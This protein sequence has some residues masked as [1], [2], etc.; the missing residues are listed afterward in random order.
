MIRFYKKVNDFN[1]KYAF[2]EIALI[3]VGITLA[4]WFN[5]WN[6]N[7]I[8]NSKK[9]QYLTELKSDLQND[10]D[11][12]SYLINANQRRMR[13][14]NLLNEIL[15]N[16]KLEIN[17]D[18]VQKCMASASFINVFTGSSTVFED[19]ESTGNLLLIDNNNL[20]RRIMKYYS[21]VDSRK[22]Y[23]DLN[24]RFHINTIGTFLKKQW[25]TGALF[26]LGLNEK[27]LNEELGINDCNNTVVTVKAFQSSNQLKQELMNHV[28][29]S[30][31]IMNMNNGEYKVMQ[32]QVKQLIDLI[33]KDKKE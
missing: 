18:S 27:G 20:K 4:I 32:D 9:D 1:W 24:S 11:E 3:F 23:E 13:R 15:N 22:K 28:N 6:Q 19:L 16:A 14:I 25:N 5:N 31:L 2:G 17:C 10:L 30:Y 29:F 8:D 7:R 12:F 33:K 21:Q 26:R